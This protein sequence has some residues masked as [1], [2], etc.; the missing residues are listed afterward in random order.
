V[1]KWL[2]IN[3]RNVQVAYVPDGRID[4]M[5]ELSD[6]PPPQWRKAFGYPVSGC[7]DE[8]LMTTPVVTSN[9]VSFFVADHHAFAASMKR[10]DRA[11]ENANRVCRAVGA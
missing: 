10:V 1:A 7:P 8:L 9:K 3:C 11:V 4:V 6:T 2:S 5:I